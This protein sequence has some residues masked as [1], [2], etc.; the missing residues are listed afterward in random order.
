MP[1]RYQAAEVRLADHHMNSCR[2]SQ[3]LSSNPSFLH[4]VGNVV[5]LFFYT[6]RAVVYAVK[7]S[8]NDG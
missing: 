3:R 1:D 2:R 5:R 7:M 6:L 8:N 4:Q